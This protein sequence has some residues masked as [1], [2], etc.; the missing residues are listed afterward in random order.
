MITKQKSYLIYEFDD[1]GGLL[2]KLEIIHE[3]E[4]NLLY[5]KMSMYCEGS[6]DEIMRAYFS[7]EELEKVI[8]QLRERVAE[9]KK[10]YEY[11][12]VNVNPDPGESIEDNEETFYEFTE[13]N[14]DKLKNNP[15]MVIE[16]NDLLRLEIV[17]DSLI[18]LTSGSMSIRCDFDSG[19]NA[20]LDCY[21]ELTEEQRVCT[22]YI[23]LTWFLD[24]FEDVHNNINK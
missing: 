9:F 20:C 6:Y 21:T 7:E 19:T 17:D 13:Y 24:F 11:Y 3:P 10:L 2:E 5:F 15:S 22:M 1:P 23:L 16:F 14:K 8:N 12:A 4:N 18:R